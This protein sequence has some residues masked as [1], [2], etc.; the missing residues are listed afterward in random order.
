MPHGRVRRSQLLGRDVANCFRE[1]LRRHDFL[2]SRRPWRG[3][4]RDSDVADRFRSR[5]NLLDLSVMVRS[6]G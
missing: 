6:W 2:G 3:L 5:S 4:C 1:H